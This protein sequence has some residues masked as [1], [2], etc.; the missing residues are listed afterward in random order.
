M[1]LRFS[2]SVS[3]FIFI[4]S[5]MTWKS[6][7]SILRISFVVMNPIIFPCSTT[8]SLRIFFFLNFLR[9]SVMSSDGF[10]VMTFRFIRALAGIFFKS[11]F[12]FFTI[13]QMMSFSV[14]IPLILSPSLITKLPTLFLTIVLA[15]SRRFVSG[16][17]W[18]KFLVI[19]SPTLIPVSIII[20]G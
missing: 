12:D 4:V 2:F 8:G 11:Y 14:R 15:Q 20:V 10:I 18:T 13:A 5:A 6:P 3:S 16:V 19:K 17:T 1:L 9:A 7:G